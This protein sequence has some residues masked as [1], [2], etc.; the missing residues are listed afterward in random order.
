MVDP[1]RFHPGLDGGSIRERLG[2]PP[3]APVAGMISRFQPYRRH[4]LVVEA[5]VDVVRQIPDAR[6]VLIG[7]GENEARIRELVERKSLSDSVIFA[8]YRTDDFP[9]HVA[10]L[11]LLI[12][13]RPGSDGSCR[14]VLEAMA[15]GRPCLVAPVGALLDLVQDDVTGVVV[16]EERPEALAAAVVDLLSSPRKML[17]MGPRGRQLVERRHTPAHVVDLFEEVYSSAIASKGT[18][19]HEV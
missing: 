7:R 10:A 17:G 3:G 12:Y 6:L 5:W 8:G 4:D 15:V 1:Q 19:E 9:Q 14:T 16:R 13:L 11:D 2:I 18:P